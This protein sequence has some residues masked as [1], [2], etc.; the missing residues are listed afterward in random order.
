VALRSKTLSGPE[1]TAWSGRASSQPALKLSSIQLGR[2]NAVKHPN[3]QCSCTKETAKMETPLLSKQAANQ[4]NIYE[5][6]FNRQKA[7]FATN[8]T[9]SYEWR[10]DQLDRLAQLLSEHTN[11]FYEAVSRDFKTALSEKVFEVG[12]TLGTIEVTKSLLKSWM[13]PTEAPVPKFLAA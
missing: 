11:E 12:A 1:M 2:T 5:D 10:V 3:Q 9:R 8:I 7:Y 6:L 4:E 13:Q